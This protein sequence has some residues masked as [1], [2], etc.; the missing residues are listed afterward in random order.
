[1]VLGE[2]KG[3]HVIVSNWANVVVAVVVGDII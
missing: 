3:D 1:M 2:R